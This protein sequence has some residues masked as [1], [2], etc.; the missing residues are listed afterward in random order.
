M[1]GLGW[2]IVRVWLTRWFYD[3]ANAEKK[4]LDDVADAFEKWER[5]RAREESQSYDVAGQN[6]AEQDEALDSL[7]NANESTRAPFY[8]SC[9]I[10]NSSSSV[11]KE[12]PK[13]KAESRDEFKR[14]YPSL[15]YLNQDAFRDNYRDFYD[16]RTLPIVEKQIKKIVEVEGPITENLILE[17]IKG[18]WNFS[19]AGARIKKIVES[20]WQDLA[21]TTQSDGTR[22]F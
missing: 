22:V 17:R 15:D 18:V 6:D 7:E 13:V 16:E 9:E 4:L 20:C 12:V 10:P 11:K 1:E 8:A 19:G 21:Q 2:R 5:K 3:R 14:A